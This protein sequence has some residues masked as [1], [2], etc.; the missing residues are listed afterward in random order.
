MYV[1]VILVQGGKGYFLSWW[2]VE[3]KALFNILTIK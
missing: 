1:Y 3:E 2:F